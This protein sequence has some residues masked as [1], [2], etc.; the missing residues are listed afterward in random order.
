MAV[1]YGPLCVSTRKHRDRGE[2]QNYKQLYGETIADLQMWT[3]ARDCTRLLNYFR[4]HGGLIGPIMDDASI[5]ATLKAFC[6]AR[7]QLK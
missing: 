5:E 6:S 1:T 4:N 2:T 7:S 3:T